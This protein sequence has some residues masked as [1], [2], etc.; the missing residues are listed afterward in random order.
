MTVKRILITVLSAALAFILMSVT[1]ERETFFEAGK[2]FGFLNRS[3]PAV[4]EVSNARYDEQYEIR[5]MLA[6]YNELWNDAGKNGVV[7]ILNNLP[8]SDELRERAILEMR[9][10]LERDLPRPVGKHNFR[11][12]EI[13]FTGP[14][15]AEASTVEDWE[16]GDAVHTA[17]F[18]R[19]SMIYEV[20]RVGGKW[21]VDEL[22]PESPFEEAPQ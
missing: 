17:V 15:S 16:Y 20:K 5:Q 7:S 18:F 21:I 8:A 11:L 22:F 14:V 4:S 19:V 6:E 3:T 10:V 1:E 2:L 13:I 12:S 9:M